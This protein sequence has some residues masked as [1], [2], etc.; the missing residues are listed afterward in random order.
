MDIIHNRLAFYFKIKHK[1]AIVVRPLWP[2][3]ALY[4]NMRF[5]FSYDTTVVNG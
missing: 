4:S 3:R 1:D 5:N 2:Q